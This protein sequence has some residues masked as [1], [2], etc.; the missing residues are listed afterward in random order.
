MRAE[1]LSYARS[2]G[3]FAGV[4]LDG[5]VL[6]PDRDDNIDLYG[7]NVDPKKLLTEGGKVPGPAIHLIHL[8]QRYDQ[9][10]KEKTAKSSGN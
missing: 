10:A 9:E 6:K 8:L 3:L 7:K 5:S 4:S 2:R 1:I